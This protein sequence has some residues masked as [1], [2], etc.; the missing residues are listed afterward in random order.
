MVIGEVAGV[1]A[2]FGHAGFGSEGRVSTTPRCS[3]PERAVV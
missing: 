2:L 1:L 3:S